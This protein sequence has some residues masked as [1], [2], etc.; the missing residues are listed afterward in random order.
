MDNTFGIAIHGGAGTP[1]KQKMTAQIMQDYKLGLE[2]ALNAGLAVLRRDGPALLAVEEA[3]VALEHE[4][5]RRPRGA[6][7][8]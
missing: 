4:L 3:V 7:V 1:D 2:L 6:G 5:R 8:V